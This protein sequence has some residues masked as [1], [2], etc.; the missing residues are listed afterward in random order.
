M[1]LFFAAGSPTTEMSHE[2]LQTNLFTALDM[3]LPRNKV[4]VVPPDF[5]R[6]HSQAG[7]LTE[8]AWEYY[9]DKLTDVLPAL[10]THKAMTDQEIATIIASRECRPS[11]ASLW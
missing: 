3:L 11:P 7:V 10:G 8:L 6:F 1:S 9:G 4:L 5:T 2:E